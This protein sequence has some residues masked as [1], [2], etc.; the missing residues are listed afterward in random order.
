MPQQPGIGYP[1]S[2]ATSLWRAVCL[3]LFEIA[4]QYGYNDF[5]EPNALDNETSSMRKCVIYSAF[6][7]NH[8]P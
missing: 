3:N 7:V 4:Q 1:P 5:L 8:M 2:S 6:I